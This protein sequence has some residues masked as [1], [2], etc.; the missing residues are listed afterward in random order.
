MS[1]EN[2]KFAIA[3]AQAIAI[4]KAELRQM[5]EADNPDLDARVVEWRGVLE[6]R[7]FQRGEREWKY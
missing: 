6:A 5:L 1:L 7:K 3:T 2:N 4:S